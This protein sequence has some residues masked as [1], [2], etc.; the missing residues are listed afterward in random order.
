MQED[1]DSGENTERKKG[2]WGLLE[3]ERR[4]GG[5]HASGKVQQEKGEKGETLNAE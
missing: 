4:R 5:G 1:G 2:V 3:G